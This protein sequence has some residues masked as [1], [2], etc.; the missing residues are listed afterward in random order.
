MDTNANGDSVATQ[1]TDSVVQES[2][3]NDLVKHETYL[4]VLNEAKK[5]KSDRNE[6]MEKLAKYDQEKLE[7]EG[8]KDEAYATLKKKNES[9]ENELKATKQKFA[10]SAV[11][12]QIKNHAVEQGCT[13]T[14]VLLKLL[15]KESLKSL[16]ID[17][18]Y[19]VDKSGL[20]GLI[21]SSKKQFAD[22]N[23]FGKRKV[24][25]HDVQGKS[26]IKGPSLDEMMAKAKTPEEV[27]KLIKSLT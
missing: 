25:V 11:E 9:L 21:E 27:A 3:K 24:E 23:L 22:L 26:K 4:K 2:K 12:G 7:L 18:N 16:E 1:E 17:D 5:A 6:L 15:D 13:N 10:W 20:S 8:K 19:Q 14:D